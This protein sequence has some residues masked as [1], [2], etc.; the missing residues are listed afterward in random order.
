VTGLIV[1]CCTTGVID[2]RAGR[3]DVLRQWN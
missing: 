3:N 1:S 2:Q